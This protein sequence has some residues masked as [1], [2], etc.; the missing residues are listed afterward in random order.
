M[1]YDYLKDLEEQ[2]HPKNPPPLPPVVEPEIRKRIF[3]YE[4]DEVKLLP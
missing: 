1:N 4:N 3:I 2:K